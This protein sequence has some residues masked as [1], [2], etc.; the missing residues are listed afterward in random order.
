MDSSYLNLE[1]QKIR[2]FWVKKSDCDY[3]SWKMVR[4]RDN[5]G[6]FFYNKGTIECFYTI[7]S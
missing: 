4:Y 5:F 3:Y 1:C 2:Q 7:S 6:A